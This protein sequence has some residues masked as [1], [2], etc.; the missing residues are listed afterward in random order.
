MLIVEVN[1]EKNIESALRIYKNKVQKTKLVQ[2]LRNRKEY[3]K[4]SVKK[5][6]QKLKAI[7]IERLKNG[8]E[9]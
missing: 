2:E 4:L 8:L 3:V 9:D 5:R 6:N 7:H 1:K